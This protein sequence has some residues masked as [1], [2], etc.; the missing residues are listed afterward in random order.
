MFKN[1]TNFKKAITERLLVKYGKELK[2]CSEKQIYEAL[3]EMTREY[4]T[5]AW[6]KTNDYIKDNKE[7]EL[8][9]FSKEFLIGRLL[10]SNLVN[11]GAYQVAKKGLEELGFDINRIEDQEADG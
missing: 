2:E 11:L 5:T 7:K 4:A 6:K 10:T 1:K 3:G 9:Y 8:V